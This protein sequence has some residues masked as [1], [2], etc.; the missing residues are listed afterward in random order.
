MAETKLLLIY[1]GGTIGMAF[2]PTQNSLIPLNFKNLEEQIPELARVP[3]DIQVLSFI[4]PIDSSEMHPQHWV[5]MAQIIQEN[6]EQFDGFVVLHGS[7]TLAYTSSALSFMLE[8]LA[9]PV[10]LT[11]SQLPIN[12]PR[13]DGKE[14]LITALELAA[15]KNKDGLPMVPEVS[16]YFDSQLLRGNRAVKASSEEFTAFESP[17]FPAIAKAGVHIKFREKIIIPPSNRMLCVHTNYSDQVGLLKLYPGMPQFMWQQLLN[18]DNIKGLV[19]ESFGSGNSMKN[20]EFIAALSEL[21]SRG[22][23]IITVTQCQSGGVS[24]GKYASGKGLQKADVQSGGD[25]TT[26]AALTKL[27]I[28]L[29]RGKTPEDIFL[30][31][32]SNVAGE[33]SLISSL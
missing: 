19:I 23:V 28:G 24:M 2:D 16:V 9:K 3:A 21:S 29:G 7:D 22:V 6:Y 14:N 17:N 11:G 1:T 33:R 12:T 27:M 25:M 15:A 5:K 8:N 18:S 4:E 30:Y 32:Q 26:E 10:I 31:M 20:P 13:T